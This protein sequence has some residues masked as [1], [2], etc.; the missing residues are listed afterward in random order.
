MN[1]P[2]LTVY[3]MLEFRSGCADT[4]VKLLTKTMGVLGHMPLPLREGTA[5]PLFF[6]FAQ[7]L[8]TRALAPTS[9]SNKQQTDELMRHALHVLACSSDGI[10]EPFD[11]TVEGMRSTWLLEVRKAFTP[12]RQQVWRIRQWWQRQWGG[13]LRF[14]VL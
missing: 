12:Q 1:L 7:V 11:P 10:W 14:D 3:A 8:I 6:S 13:F 9:G 4:A 5:P 2:L